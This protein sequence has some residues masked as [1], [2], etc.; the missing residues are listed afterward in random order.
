[1]AMYGDC[2]HKINPVTSGTCATLVFDI[3]GSEKKGKN[4]HC[5]SKEDCDYDVRCFWTEHYGRKY[6]PNGYSGRKVGCKG[7]TE[8]EK[9][10][11]LK[12]FDAELETSGPDG[13]LI[14]L[15]HLYPDYQNATP[16]VLQDADS[17]LYEVL[18][19][20]T[21]RTGH[22]IH[23]NPTFS[24]TVAVN[25]HYDVAIVTVIL[26]RCQY[27]SSRDVDTTRCMVFNTAAVARE[28][29]LDAGSDEDDNSIEDPEHN[30]CIGESSESSGS[31]DKD[32]DFIEE[33]ADSE[34]DDT[35]E[36][37]D[38]RHNQTLE[39]AE[40]MEEDEEE[41]EEW[42]EDEQ[43]SFPVKN[44]KAKRTKVLI[45][46]PLD[47]NGLLDYKQENW[48]ACQP[49]QLVFITSCLQVR[50]NSNV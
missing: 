48:K 46:Y 1:V 22:N 34:G 7:L 29:E 5:R 27:K 15:Q 31:V 14:A 28:L 13:V 43:E 23:L 10:H 41:E 11:L 2:L 36:E 44:T 50:K 35:L 45:P 37:A 42:E 8:V 6:A 30:M 24:S 12:T 38:D 25:N 21:A 18:T 47:V 3:Y 16:S 4:A 39:E 9:E 33:S 40:E 26:Y 17:I 32:V 19:G 49:E 20:A